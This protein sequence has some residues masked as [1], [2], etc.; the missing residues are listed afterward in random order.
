MNDGEESDGQICL[1]IDIEQFI[2]ESIYS[3]RFRGL[4]YELE[5]V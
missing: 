3:K 2:W 1:I 5:Y 4:S